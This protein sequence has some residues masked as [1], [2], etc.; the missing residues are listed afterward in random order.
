MI[1]KYNGLIVGNLFD[2]DKNMSDFPKYET[3][4]SCAEGLQ[5]TLKRGRRK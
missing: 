4:Y 3:F 5:Q 2:E 1:K